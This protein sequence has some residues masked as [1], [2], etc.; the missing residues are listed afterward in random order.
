M[1]KNVEFF[2]K[3]IEKIEIQITNNDD[4]YG[5]HHHDGWMDWKIKNKTWK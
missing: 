1:Q 5:D 4:D 3:K 2:S